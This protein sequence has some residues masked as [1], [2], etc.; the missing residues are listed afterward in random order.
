MITCECDGER[1][2]VGLL[3]LR[4]LLTVYLPFLMANFHRYFF[5]FFF[6]VFLAGLDKAGCVF[7]LHLGW[8]RH[9]M[10]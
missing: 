3:R 7:L 5:F 8:I 9:P 4:S 10:F 1:R 6:L 2:A